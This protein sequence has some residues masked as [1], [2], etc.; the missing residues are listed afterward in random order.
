MKESDMARVV[1][2][3]DKVLMNHDNE[4]AVEGV[5]HEVNEWMKSFPLYRNTPVLMG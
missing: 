5:R 4:S 2:L 1:E 3:I